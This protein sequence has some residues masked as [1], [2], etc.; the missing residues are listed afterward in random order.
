MK[1]FIVI[2]CLLGYLLGYLILN[3]TLIHFYL[4]HWQ[5]QFVKRL[6][7]ARKEVRNYVFEKV[8][9]YSHESLLMEKTNANTMKL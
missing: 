6:T 1:K 2:N 9:A 5:A 7:I 4:F 3:N 8:C